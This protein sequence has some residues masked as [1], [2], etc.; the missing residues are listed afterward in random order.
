MT[1]NG[2][3]SLNG[4]SL[5]SARISYILQFEQR[6]WPMVLFRD[7]RYV[8]AWREELGKRWVGSTLVNV[9]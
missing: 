7:E 1:L 3:A 9:P 5:D 2:G 8:G 6:S 4:E